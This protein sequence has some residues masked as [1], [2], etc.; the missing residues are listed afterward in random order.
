[1]SDETCKK[2]FSFEVKETEIGTKAAEGAGRGS[3]IGGTVGA[4]A[5]VI[6]PIGTSLIIPG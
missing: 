4:I 2:H 5:G 6:A 3:A 1:M